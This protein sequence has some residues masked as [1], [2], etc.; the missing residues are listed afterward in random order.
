MVAV[1]EGV[2]VVLVVV[3]L[4][5]PPPSFGLDVVVVVAAESGVVSADDVGPV[6]V[7]PVAVTVWVVVSVKTSVVVVFIAVLSGGS[8]GA[9]ESES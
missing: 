8:S 4:Q 9:P 1:V 2:V 3:V 6:E 5:P 7:K